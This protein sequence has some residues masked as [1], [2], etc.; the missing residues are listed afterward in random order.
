LSQDQ[1]ADERGHSG[2]QA[3]QQKRK[4]KKM[5][6]VIRAVF[7]AVYLLSLGFVAGSMFEMEFGDLQKRMEMAEIT[8]GLC[9]DQLERALTALEKCR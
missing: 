2:P 3:T 6:E 9:L 7:I 1:K 8:T 4:D 5:K